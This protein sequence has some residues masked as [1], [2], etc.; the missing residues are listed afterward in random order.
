MA[1]P[2]LVLLPGLDGTGDFFAPLLDSLGARVRTRVVRY[3]LKEATDYATCQAIAR[4]ALPADRPYVLLGESFSG[5]IAVAIAATAPPGLRGLI[6]SATFITNPRPRLSILRPLLPFIPFR[7]DPLSLA[8]SR[9]RVL[10]HWATPA[11]R[12]LHRD[13]QTKLPPEMIRARLRT[14]MDCDVRDALR[15]V[16]VPVLCLTARH[17]RLI[18]KSAA[19]LI[20]QTAPATAVVQ[21]D[22]PHCLLQCTPRPAADAIRAFLSKVAL[23][24]KLTTA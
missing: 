10:G 9:F 15:S 14:V 5:P 13:I 23:P 18:P 20:Q 24:D 21:L 11:L 17:D 16:R 8:L 19:R 12:D 1:D 2:E 6:L 3:P 7:S 22:A 4:K